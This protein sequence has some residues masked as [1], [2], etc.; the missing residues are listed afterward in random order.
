MYTFFF[1]QFLKVTFQLVQNISY[2]PRVVQY[3]RFLFVLPPLKL[4][5]YPAPI[6][7]PKPLSL[8]LSSFSLSSLTSPKPDSWVPQN[9][10]LHGPPYFSKWR[11]FST[12]TL[13]SSLVPLFTH[14]PQPIPP[15]PSLPA[16][17]STTSHLD[18]FDS[19]PVG[20]QAFPVLSTV[21]SSHN[22]GNDPSKMSVRSRA[23]LAQ[24]P[25]VITHFPQSINKI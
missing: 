21:F 19:F 2:I 5:T 3:T 17:S 15:R 20:L 14:A 23:F 12:K 6:S 22:N 4:P 10:S 24:N 18:Y 25:L 16:Q 7:H 8:C 13:A 9:V 11:L 1:I